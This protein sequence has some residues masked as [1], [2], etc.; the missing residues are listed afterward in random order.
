[1]FITQKHL[2]R[3]TLLRGAGA[4]IALP[5]LNSMI[6]AQTPLRKTAAAARTRFA[7]IE[8]VHGS[9]G[10]TID[11]TGKH[12]WSPP[13]EGSN[14][15]ITPTLQSLEPYRDYLTIVSG[16]DL[17][18]ASALSPREEGADHTRSSAVFLTAAHPKMTEGSDIYLGTSIDQIY[19]QHSSQQENAA[20][21]PSIQLAIEDVGSLSGACGY[22]YSCVYAN[23]ISWASPT[24]PLPMEIDPRVA[25][26]RL[27]GDGAT[28]AERSARREADRSV[29][30]TIRQEVARLTKNLGPGDRS[31]LNEYLDNVREIESR[32]QRVEK[33]N[34]SG[35][36]RALPEAP[37]G[38]PDSFEEHVKLMFDLQVLAFMTD[39]TRVSAFKLSRDVSSRVYPESGVKQPFHGLSHHGE[40]PETIARF[41]K[42]NQYHVSKAAYFIDKLKN[43]PD[44]DGNLLDHSIVLYGS[45]MGDSNIHDH[46]HLPIFLA[47]KGN[48]Q[49]R[50]NL[51][52]RAPEDTPMANLLLTLAH[53][54]GVND[55]TNI[56]D[57]TGELAI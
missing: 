18:N 28:P 40:N 57:S 24:Q 3:R 49:L 36:Q 55:V 11:G 27:F 45:P 52:Y 38:V 37:V 15:E 42:L 32:I 34:A 8:I 21:L 51:H 35:A 30:D 47:G 50:G 56:G 17:H 48:G 4:A 10:S 43:T 6:A 31:R 23:T 12:Y 20:P 26:E 29:L 39:T 19:A 53:K 44:G 7:A 33:F 9:A 25:F 54:L 46:K 14:F 41:A 2:S 16:T 13:A 22:G 5:L 1:M